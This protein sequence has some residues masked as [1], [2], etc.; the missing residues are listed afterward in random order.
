MHPKRDVW[1]S[2]HSTPSGPHGMNMMVWSA[3]YMSNTLDVRGATWTK[4]ESDFT[5]SGPRGMNIVF[6]LRA[7]HGQDP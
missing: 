4:K 2:V 6:G 7:A 5:H 1:C 3:A